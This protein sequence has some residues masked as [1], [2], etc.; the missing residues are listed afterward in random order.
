MVRHIKW[1]HL[2]TVILAVVLAVFLIFLFSSSLT[3]DS[4]NPLTGN[5]VLGLESVYLPNENLQGSVSVYLAEGELIPASS[6]FVVSVNGNNYY[7]VLSDLVDNEKV[8]GDFYL[9]NVEIS[10]NGEGYGK[11]GEKPVDFVLKI[12]SVSSEVSS[13]VGTGT[14]LESEESPVGSEDNTGSE[15]SSEEI[16]SE[17][18]NLDESEVATNGESNVQNNLENNAEVNSGELTSEENLDSGS[19]ETETNGETITNEN[20]EI[21][22]NEE[23]SNSESSVSN[24]ETASENSGS[25]GTET[26]SA[27]SE[28]ASENSNSES[29][30][31][32][33]S[34]SQASPITGSS[35]FARFFRPSISGN[36]VSENSNSE[37]EISGSVKSSSNFEY[38]LREG[39]SF[40]L[41]SSD[42][43]VSISQEGNKIT[44]SL[45]ESDS[46]FGEDYLG[47]EKYGIIVNLSSLE[48]LAEEGA[49][50]ISLS[51][52]GIDIK[53]VSSQINSESAGQI[54]GNESSSNETLGNVSILNES[55]VNSISL[56]ESNLTIEKE[57]LGDYALTEDELFVLKG[58]T[59]EDKVSVTK[60]DIVDG[61]LI[62]RSE[63]GNYW[64]ENSYD[65]SKNQEELNALVAL[66]IAKWVKNLAKNLAEDEKQSEKAESFIGDYNLSVSK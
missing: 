43:P 52:E 29:S 45:D 26:I 32:E 25:A 47:N 35:I 20:P 36:A 50:E 11:E 41:V 66:D 59:G 9:Q 39:E 63:I 64:I 24:E 1:R 49:L 33:S 18:N 12:N 60:A 30:T 54:I 4:V 44:V 22:S 16:P 14:G 40:E 5:V 7:Y 28:S 27:G 3:G 13:G 65:S 53:K 10:G 15:N 31:T 21:V 23:N 2:S 57:S 61:R 46:G 38:E 8:S 48:I 37:R 19:V 56:N 6:S 55:L 42:K 62:I 58:K 51:Y 34:N 17:N